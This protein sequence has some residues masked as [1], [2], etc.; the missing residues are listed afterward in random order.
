MLTKQLIFNQED[1]KSRTPGSHMEKR[2]LRAS[3]RPGSIF[4]DDTQGSFSSWSYPQC[5]RFARHTDSYDVLNK[6]ETIVK[7]SPLFYSQ[8]SVA[9]KT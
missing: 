5:S 6:R 4:W 1:K 3:S 8:Y 7:E 9:S 2:Y